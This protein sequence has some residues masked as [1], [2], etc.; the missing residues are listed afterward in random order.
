MKYHVTSSLPLGPLRSTGESHIGHDETTPNHIYLFCDAVL[1][2]ILLILCLCLKE[3]NSI[4]LQHWT[5][6]TGFSWITSCNS[7]ENYVKST[8]IILSII[9]KGKPSQ[10]GLSGFLR[11]TQVVNGSGR[12]WT[13]TVWFRNSHLVSPSRLISQGN[14]E[15]G[16][17]SVSVRQWWA[18][19]WVYPVGNGKINYGK[20]KQ[21]KTKN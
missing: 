5:Y 7:H 16:A 11:M 20:G 9:E 14:M 10:E 15:W 8:L 3:K 2:S 13:W 21:N 6:S 1:D 4:H 18:F 17:S 12:V 19:F